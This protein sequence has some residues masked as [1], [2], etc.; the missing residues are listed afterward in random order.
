M[1]SMPGEAAV[2]RARPL[3][4]PEVLIRVQRGVAACFQEEMEPR[5]VLRQPRS[6][7]AAA[8]CLDPRGRAT[9]GPRG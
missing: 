8:P 3:L 1:G 7:R 5:P 4:V 2:D 6:P 9:R